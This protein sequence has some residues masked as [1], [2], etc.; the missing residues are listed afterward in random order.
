MQDEAH[1]FQMK[2]AYEILLNH[3]AAALFDAPITADLTE[4]SINEAFS[5]AVATLLPISSD[6]RCQWI[7]ANNLRNLWEHGQ[8]HK[9]LT[10]HGIPYAILKG[11]ASAAYYPDPALRTMGDVDFIVRQDGIER[12]CEA[13][14]KL[15]FT[16]AD[17]ESE[18][19][20]VFRKAQ[21]VW[22]LH[23]KAPGIPVGN[24]RIEAILDTII[25]DA[26]E[27]DG[28]M[29]PSKFHHGLVLLLH[30]AEHLLNTGIGLRHLCD[31]AMFY[32]SLSNDAFVATFQESLQ[33]VGLWRFAQ[34]LTLTCVRYLGAPAREWAGTS[35]EGLL[36]SIIEDIL[37]GGNFGIKDEQRINQAKLMTNGAER[38]VDG[39]SVH[40][41]LASIRN[42]AILAWPLCGRI[43][44]MLPLGC[45]YVCIRHLF[46][47]AK[48]E[49]PAIH[50]RRVLNGVRQRKRLYREFKLFQT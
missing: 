31:W 11:A 13:I 21:S 28:C 29:V 39:G 37:S 16:C 46:R 35:D 40:H 43:K 32:S 22:E 27:K 7:L 5:Q 25:D 17:S 4:E 47:I 23:W 30:T 26:E 6:K 42:K 34:L 1:L 9:L 44:I 12:T 8:L 2:D 10:E 33:S 3:I 18:H 45:F 20:V 36:E 14:K 15:G 50:T 48:G 49:R 24:Q 19:H 38:S 41:L